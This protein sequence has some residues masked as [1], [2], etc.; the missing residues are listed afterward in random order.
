MLEEQRQEQATLQTEKKE[1]ETLAANI[2]TVERSYEAQI[3]E[4]QKQPTPSTAKYNASSA[5]RLSR[6]TNVKKSVWQPSTEA[7]AMRNHKAE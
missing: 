3:R 7:K 5:W 1:L 2:R 6:L 4:K